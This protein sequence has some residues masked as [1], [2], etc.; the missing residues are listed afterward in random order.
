MAQIRKN[1][2]GDKKVSVRSAKISCSRK[3][4][5]HDEA[6][7][8]TLRFVLPPQNDER[9]IAVLNLPHDIKFNVVM[10]E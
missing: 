10:N 8:D 9:P 5:I 2:G 1:R 3:L 4:T 6:V 7:V